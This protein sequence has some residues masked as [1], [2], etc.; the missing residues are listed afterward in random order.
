MNFELKAKTGRPQKLR[1]TA[2]Q[3]ALVR[4][5]SGVTVSRVCKDLGISRQTFYRYKKIYDFKGEI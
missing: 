5:K 3:D 4:L 2:F 1:K